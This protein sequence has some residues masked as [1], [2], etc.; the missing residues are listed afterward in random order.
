M[1]KA[2]PV[3]VFGRLLM[4]GVVS[5]LAFPHPPRDLSADEL[6]QRPDLHFVTTKNNLQI[7][8]IYIHDKAF[9][10]TIIYSHGNG[11]DV[12]I[13]LPFLD[14]LSNRCKA[15]VV[16]YE[17]AGYSIAEGSPS[18]ANCYHCIDA[19]F[20]FLTAPTSSGKPRTDPSRVVIF[21]RSLG[22]GPSV[23][24]A[25]RHPDVAGLALQS[26]LESGVRVILG[27]AGSVAL[28]PFDIFRNYQK[29]QRVRCSVFIMHGEEDR[30]VP[31]AH[32]RALH[33]LL[34]HRPNAEQLRYQA[35]WYPQAGHNDMPTD[36]CLEELAKF[37]QYL[38][39]SAVLQSSSSKEAA[40]TGTGC[41]TH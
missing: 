2:V 29:I 25:S 9:H 6:T 1:H 27:N 34:D 10:F 41:S 3:L 32:G 24:L 23:D 5:S 14:Y 20:E 13:S 19:A 31:C 28:Y 17:Y 37:L 39:G 30:V 22:S 26:P 15:N 36:D 7:P 18:E 16:A 21:G 38:R 40:S 35:K 4:G 11:E 12:G 33:A 8:L